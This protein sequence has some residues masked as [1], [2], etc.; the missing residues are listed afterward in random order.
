MSHPYQIPD[1]PSPTNPEDAARWDHTRLR[2]R[3]LEGTWQDD[4]RDRYE[5][6]MGITRARAHGELDMS[7]NPFR[8]IS[9]ELSVLYDRAP[10]LR[11][12]LE[13]RSDVGAFMGPGGPIAGA[14]LWSLM[15]WFQSRVIGCREY[16][17]RVDVAAD[18]EL[19]YRPVPP[20]MVLATGDAEYPDR[21]VRIAEIRPRML[22]GKLLWTWDVYDISNAEA[23][24][25]RVHLTENGTPN[26][27]DITADVLGRTYEGDDYWYRRADGRPILPFVLYHAQKRGDRLWD[28][29]DGV[30]VVEGTINLS[31]AWSY[32]FHALRDAS[33]SQRY[34]V[35]LRP[36]G[37]ATE[38]TTRGTRQ[39][40]TTDPATVLLLESTADA[41][42]GGQPMVGQW[43]SPT[44]VEAME[45]AIS[46]FSNRLAQDAGIPPSDIQRMG[47]T[48]RSG[49]AISLSN[50]GK[51]SAQ[52]RFASQFR[53]HDEALVALSA[54]LVNRAAG[55]ALPEDGYSVVYREISLSPSE[56][57]ERRAN[58]I[59]LLAA[60]LIDR[61]KGYLELNPGLTEEQARADLAAIDGARPFP[62]MNRTA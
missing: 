14:G 5:L 28:C 17:M 46:A 2:R 51:R 15:G 60:G 18:G 27:A 34:T 26:G 1:P 13:R 25:Y 8:V 40:V 45:R 43:T 41:A 16:L 62:Q 6:H 58:V 3:L 12:D 59:E 31:I 52:R 57:A 22:G 44:D 24:S 11:H 37:L 10:D 32:W 23:P 39:E 36:A 9:R 50:A 19:H 20:D 33:W 48:A 55:S 42:E 53:R 29:Y 61:I 47:G 21:P 7:S 35:N 30:E 49:Y 38:D 56:L 4:L 54:T